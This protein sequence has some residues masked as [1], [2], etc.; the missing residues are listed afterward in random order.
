MA[1][2]LICEFM[3]DLIEG[4]FC[5]SCFLSMSVPVLMTPGGFGRKSLLFPKAMFGC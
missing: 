3:G 4:W 5:S 1:P 2:W